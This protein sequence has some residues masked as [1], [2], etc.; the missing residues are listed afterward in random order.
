MSSRQLIVIGTSA[1]ELDALRIL[2]ECH[3]VLLKIEG[4]GH[5]R[6]AAIPDTPTRPEARS[7]EI[8]QPIDDALSNAIRALEEGGLLFR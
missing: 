5:S 6:Y 8:E 2:G 4:S 7:Q 1:C 3:G